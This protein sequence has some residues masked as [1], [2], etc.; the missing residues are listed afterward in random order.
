MVSTQVSQDVQAE[1]RAYLV[2]GCA[3]ECSSSL[4]DFSVGCSD[5]AAG[6]EALSLFP[7]SLPALQLPGPT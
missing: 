4:A 7:C 2:F 3:G 1:G 6:P 5:S